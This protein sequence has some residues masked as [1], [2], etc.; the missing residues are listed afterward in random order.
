MNKYYDIIN[1]KR[2][3]SKYPCLSDDS[4]ASQFAP[5]D[6]LTGFDDEVRETSRQVKRKIQVDE[7]LRNNLNMKLA[8]L[9]EH[10]NEEMTVQVKYFEKDKKK[11]GGCYLTK[12]CI[13]KRIDA[14]NEIIKLS[15]NQVIA[16][17][18]ILDIEGDIFE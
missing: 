2:P 4:R 9:S 5:F 6:A 17:K 18:D 10:L 8:F 12:R 11:D 7:E 16:M 3:V 13:I 14:V 15:D 1:L